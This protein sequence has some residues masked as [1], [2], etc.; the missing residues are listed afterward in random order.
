MNAD[1]PKKRKKEEEEEEEH[2]ANQKAVDFVVVVVVIYEQCQHVYVT[3]FLHIFHY[4]F[5]SIKLYFY[6]NYNTQH[7]TVHIHKNY[8]LDQGN[9]CHSQG[10]VHT[11]G[12]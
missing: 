6:V 10:V 5:Y 2:S 9:V 1:G 4:I 12:C 7:F 3:K 8:S 11:E